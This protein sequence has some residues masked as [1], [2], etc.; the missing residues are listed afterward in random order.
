MAK[1]TLFGTFNFNFL[2]ILT[3]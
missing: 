3:W 2:K 1:I